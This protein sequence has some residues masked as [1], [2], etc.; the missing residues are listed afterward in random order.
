MER[1]RKVDLSKMSEEEQYALGSR[2]GE[3]LRKMIDEEID[4]I[5]K[6]LNV[7]VKFSHSFS[8]DSKPFKKKRV[9]KK[10]ENYEIK[11]AEQE[12]LEKL[13]K[14]SSIYGIKTSLTLVK[15]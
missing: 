7:K 9:L 6:E 1:V 10:S 5:N 14:I 11:K 12:L 4:K 3:K 2:I 15:E 8:K 13:N